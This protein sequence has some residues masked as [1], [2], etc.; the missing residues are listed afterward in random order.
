MA[1]PLAVFMGLEQAFIYADFSKVTP[2]IFYWKQH[3]NFKL[4]V[5][6]VHFGDPPTQ[7]G[8]SGHGAAAIR[9]RLHSE[10]A[11]EDNQTLLCGRWVIKIAENTFLYR[12]VLF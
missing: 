7:L 9:G 1:A 4:V 8:V 10:H 12:V 2:S 11:A 6:G 3:Q 5:R